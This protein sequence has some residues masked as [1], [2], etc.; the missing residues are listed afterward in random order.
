MCDGFRILNETFFLTDI[1]ECDGGPC[2]NGGTCANSD[3]SYSCSCQDGWTGNDCTQ[4]MVFY[5]YLSKILGKQVRSNKDVSEVRD[6]H[7]FVR[8]ISQ[9]CQIDLSDLSDLVF[10]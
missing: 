7:R 1:N 5:L 2:K 6:Y 9:I 4:G 10:Q 8:E 3:G